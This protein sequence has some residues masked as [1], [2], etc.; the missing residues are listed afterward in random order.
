MLTK[1]FGGLKLWKSKFVF[2][3]KVLAN[4]LF[5]SFATSFAAAC[6]LRNSSLRLWSKVKSKVK[7]LLVVSG[8]KKGRKQQKRGN[9]LFP[10]KVFLFIIFYRNLKSF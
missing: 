2:I 7:S 1:I 3:T 10:P 8:G 6:S 5:R 9:I 4:L